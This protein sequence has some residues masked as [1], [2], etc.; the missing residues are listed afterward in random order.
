MANGGEGEGRVWLHE[1]LDEELLFF[2]LWTSGR[3]PNNP[4]TSV[5]YSTTSAV[6]TY[7]VGI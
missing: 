2:S 6:S 5:A 1:Q 4:I 7:I 3:T